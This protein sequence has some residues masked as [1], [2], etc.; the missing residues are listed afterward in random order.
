MLWDN[1][2]YMHH[3]PPH[4]MLDTFHT[5]FPDGFWQMMTGE[6]HLNTGGGPIYKC[7]L[8]S[9]AD[10]LWNPRA[11]DPE[12]SLRN[13]IAVLAGP[14]QVADL[15][16]FRDVFYAIYDGYTSQFGKPETFLAQVKAMQGR[17][18]D[19]EGLAEIGG[20][21]ERENALAAKI[22]AQCPNKPLAEEIVG[23]AK[24]HDTYREAVAVL[25]K[26]P[27]LNAED[28]AN[29]APNPDAEQT[30]KGRPAS[31]GLYQGA[32]QGTL[33]VAPGR[34]GGSCGKLTATKLY[35]WGDGRQS[36]NV[37]LMIGDCDGFLGD[38][39]P[40]VLP[41]HGY[42]YSFWLKG[43]APRLTVSFVT[44]NEKGTRESRG[45]VPAKPVVLTATGDWTFVSGKFVTPPT[46]ARGALKLNIEGYTDQGAGL[47]EICVDDVYVGR[48][49]AASM[50]GRP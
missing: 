5:K 35:D 48:S 20:L 49:Q 4:Y 25:A 21:L 45:G 27:P 36:I 33:T 8:L 50:K 2:I 44:W 7:G 32:G 3:N 30:A 46:A 24:L 16:A 9:A 17:P 23:R 41:L 47:G 6:V 37:A 19:D 34:G 39:A 38:K 29:I 42:Y 1:T 10:Y 40:P 31:W 28:A 43:T 18:F 26:L 14:D 13:A 11:F 22:A 12:K 15:L